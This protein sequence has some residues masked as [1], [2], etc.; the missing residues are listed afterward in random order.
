MAGNLELN[1]IRTKY[2][3]IYAGQ[4]WLAY[5]A[6]YL[7]HNGYTDQQTAQLYGAYQFSLFFT[8]IIWGFLSDKY[9]VRKIY[10]LAASIS[11]LLLLLLPNITGFTALAVYVVLLSVF[12]YG[13][14]PMLDSITLHYVHSSK[15]S[16]YGALRMFGAVGWGIASPSLGWLIDNFYPS[17]IFPYSSALLLI[18]AL[19][20][21]WLLRLDKNKISGSPVKI[22]GVLYF[23]RG[24]LLL[25]LMI[26]SFFGF[27]MAP[28]SHVITIYFKSLGASNTIVGIAF[29]M[30]TI[31]EIPLFF[32][33]AWFISRLGY[34]KVTYIAFFMG[35]V[36]LLYYGFSNEPLVAI[37]GGL[38]QGFTLSF[39]IIGVV[40][41][42]HKKVPLEWRSTGQALIWAFHFG[43]GYTLGHFWLGFVRNYYSMN[44]IM[45]I[46][47]GLTFIAFLLLW[48]YF[49]TEKE[50]VSI[51]TT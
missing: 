32:L 23:F 31:A 2:I 17:L 39:F 43:A 5:F 30:Q 27:C 37:W 20:A 38:L 14:S 33:G 15:R 25:F 4:T 34:K 49:S 16:S 29:T 50:N 7:T 28:I 22:K 11:S 42:V 46:Q 48:W 19:L 1:I 10:I 24:R 40:E 35:A 47:A 18:T 12:L 51:I 41:Y 3:L 45:F 21:L 6:V 36:R 9:G 44:E 26:I 8:V 13:C